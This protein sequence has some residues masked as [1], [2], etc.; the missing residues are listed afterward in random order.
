MSDLLCFVP[1][2]IDNDPRSPLYIAAQGPL[3]STVDE[4]W[5]MIWEQGCVAIVMLTPL[6]EE[7]EL[8]CAR[9]WPDEGSCTYSSFEVRTLRVRCCRWCFIL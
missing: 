4:F 8:Q 1:P 9:Y 3:P 5:R 2:K 7:A 6:V